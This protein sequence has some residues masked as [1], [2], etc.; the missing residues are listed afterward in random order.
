MPPAATGMMGGV[1]GLLNVA[2]ARFELD[3]ADETPP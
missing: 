3:S 2:R 1:A